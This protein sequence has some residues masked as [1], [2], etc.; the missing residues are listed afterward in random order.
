MEQF[1][2]QKNNE[3][4]ELLKE[5]KKNAEKFQEEKLR[6]RQEKNDEIRNLIEENKI[7][8]EERQEEMLKNQKEMQK[9][10][11]QKMTK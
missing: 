1:Q 10:Q 2:E 7:K 3:I 6:Y 4:K 11:Q 5:N 8:E 9:L